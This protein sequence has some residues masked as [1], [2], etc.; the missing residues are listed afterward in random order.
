MGNFKI[1]TNTLFILLC[2]SK[3]IWSRQTLNLLNHF[4]LLYLC[5]TPG[6]LYFCTT[7]FTM[8]IIWYYWSYAFVYD[9]FL[10]Y[11]GAWNMRNMDKTWFLL[12]SDLTLIVPLIFAF[13]WWMCNLISFEMHIYDNI[14][15]LKYWNIA[16][17][18]KTEVKTCLN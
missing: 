5:A 7:L 11:S 6:L 12:P 16:R 17:Q 13:L 4:R 18:D 15:N 3:Y 10:Q 8:S 2:S 9:V 14:F 1:L